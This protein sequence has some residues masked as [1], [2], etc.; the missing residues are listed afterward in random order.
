MIFGRY[1]CNIDKGAISIPWLDKGELSIPCYYE[2][3]KYNGK[4]FFYVCGADT[5]I[6]ENVAYLERGKCDLDKSGKW[7]LPK[8]ILDVLGSDVYI[9]IGIGDKCTLTSK[10]RLQEAEPDLDKIKDALTKL[11]L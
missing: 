9:F 8:A 2:I 6:K 3:I 5:E 7:I 10:K 4:D 1:E 11:G